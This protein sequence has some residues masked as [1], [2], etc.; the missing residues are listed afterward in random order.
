V[1][2]GVAPVPYRARAAEAALAGQPLTDATA[3]AAAK[4]AV[5][6]AT[7]LAGNA[8][9]VKIVEAIVRRTILSVPA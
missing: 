4:A 1:L 9:K 2:G 8:Y 3:R 6:G 7:P 5:Q